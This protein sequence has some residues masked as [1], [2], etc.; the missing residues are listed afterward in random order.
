[1]SEP[2]IEAIINK[3]KTFKHKAITGIKIFFQ[4]YSDVYEKIENQSAVSF[5]K[6]LT[7]IRDMKTVKANISQYLK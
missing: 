2:S 7:Y 5:G 4:N 1:M 6:V 3:V